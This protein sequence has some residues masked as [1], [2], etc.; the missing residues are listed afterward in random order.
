MIIHVCMKR[1]ETISRDAVKNKHATNLPG[2][3]ICIYAYLCLES[4][5]NTS[6]NH[7]TTTTHDRVLMRVQSK[8]PSLS[9]PH[10]LM[11]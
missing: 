6:K 1:S 5:R 9:Q 4:Y 8:Y 7:G 3:C 11:D 2:K 10:M